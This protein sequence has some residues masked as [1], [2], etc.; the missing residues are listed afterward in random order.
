[1]SDYK[2]PISDILFALKYGADVERI[3]DWDEALS[4]DVISQLSKFIEERIAPLDPVGDQNHVT[5]VDG[6][7]EMPE[8]FVQAYKD[9]CEAA[10]PTL[11]GPEEY[12]GQELPDIFDVIRA[13]ILAGSC[14]ALEIV[15]T[16]GQGAIRAILD[17]SNREQK[18]RYLPKLVSGEWLATMCMTEPQAGSDLGQIKTTGYQRSDGK[19]DLKGMKIFITGG[20]QNLTDGIVHL[21]LA[22]TPGAPAGVKGLS[23]FICPTLLPSGERNSVST[24]AVE[25]KMGMHVSPTCQLAFENAEAELIGEPGEGLKYMFSMMNAER[26]DVS[27]QGLGL[28]EVA[29]QRSLAYASE[30]V[31]GKNKSII[32]HND[33]RRML[34]RQHAYAYGNRAMIYRGTVEMCL[35][36][37]NPLIEFL[38]PVF[39]IFSTEAAC[40]A[41]NLAVQIH[42]GY[43]FCRE[44]R[45]EQIVRDS[46]ITPIYEGTNG[47]LAMTLAN[48]LLHA[49]NGKHLA[50]FEEEMLPQAH[51]SEQYKSAY[52]SWLE[53]TDICRQTRDTGTI[54]VDYARLTALIAFGRTWQ[55]LLE[56][57]DHHANP[58]F[59]RDVG[60]FV[61]YSILPETSMLAA[62]IKNYQDTNFEEVTFPEVA[63]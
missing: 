61:D 21:V 53:A 56:H 27:M 39:K 46:R 35:D 14:I 34:L 6:R 36:P 15:L 55:R 12:G 10:W 51:H 63:N 22:R 52:Q 26:L 54:A 50:A 49:N 40:E 31:Q 37:D 38:T 7:A 25:D 1:L 3:E 44:Y 59:I 45:V 42:G 30:R 58:A 8:L 19:W 20:D 60:K 28:T 18:E 29:R 48:R 24:I 41:A 47:I 4:T 33:V 57:A 32:Q 17:N 11:T 62:R 2:T 43:G 13:E 9:Y 23:L 5:L 16:L